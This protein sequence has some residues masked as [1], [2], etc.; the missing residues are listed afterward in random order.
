MSWR[1]DAVELH[2]LQWLDTKARYS[3]KLP[4]NTRYIPED[5]RNL[6]AIEIAS[7]VGGHASNPILYTGRIVS[8]RL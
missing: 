6:M 1:K 5:M 7:S 4:A 3:L 8:S 2:C